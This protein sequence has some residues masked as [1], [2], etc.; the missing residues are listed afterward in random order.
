MVTR[1]IDALKRCS[2]IN[3]HLFVY[4]RMYFCF[5]LIVRSK[6]ETALHRWFTNYRRVIDDIQ[7]TYAAYIRSTD[8]LYIRRAI[9]LE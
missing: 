1:D 3:V 2:A 6:V 4:R 7:A 8:S 9:I 5:L